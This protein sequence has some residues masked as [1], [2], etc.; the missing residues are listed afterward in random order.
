M[1]PLQHTIDDEN[2]LRFSALDIDRRL[3][4]VNF[5]PDDLARLAMARPIIAARAD[6]YVA[7]FFDYLAGFAE[8]VQLFRR[9]DMLEDAK[10]LKRAHL[11]AMA[12]GEYGKSYVAERVRLAALYGQAGLDTRIFLGAYN[13][14]L[15]QIGADIL[16][17]ADGDRLSAYRTFVSLKK[18]S[19]FDMAIIIDVLLDER[20]RTIHEQQKAIRE[21][22]TP[23]LQLL[24]GLLIL[25]II[26]AI[27]SE[28]ARQLTAALLGAIR[29]TRAR[30]VVMDVTGVGAMDTRVSNHFI[31]T[32]TAARMMGAT[33]IMSGLAPSVAQSLVTLGVD[34][35]AIE[36]VGDLQSGVDRGRRLLGYSLLKS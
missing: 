21:L 9:S 24:E 1:L 32:V 31:Q 25:P 22:S 3:Q 15:T 35:G 30:V 10:R 34:L 4:F 2:A 29:A 18:I 23:V 12:A 19:T 5:Q 17:A 27:D 13:D 11:I 28:R 26:G 8:A 6:D 16:R 20:E 36:T 7:A 33:V 14:L